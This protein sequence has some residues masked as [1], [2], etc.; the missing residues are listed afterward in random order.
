MIPADRVPR[1]VPNVLR[2]FRYLIWPGCRIEQ[3]GNRRVAR[4]R[5]G[6][7]LQSTQGLLILLVGAGIPTPGAGWVAP[8]GSATDGIAAANLFIQSLEN[9]QMWPPMWKRVS[10]EPPCGLVSDPY[11]QYFRHIPF[12]PILI[13]R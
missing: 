9:V 7:S 10:R 11:R 13:A 5:Q 1:T 8:A 12:T 4:A 6:G 3:M 2:A